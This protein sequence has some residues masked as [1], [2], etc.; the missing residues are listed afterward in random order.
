MAY[1]VRFLSS[2][3]VT[4]AAVALV[5]PARAHTVGDWEVNSGARSCTM[6]STFEDNVSIGLISPRNGA[7]SFVAGGE[8]L[9]AF[10]HP[11]Q[12]VSLDLK[13]TGKVPHDE[14][15][16]DRAAVSAASDG[17]PMVVA[18]WGATYAQ[19][20]ADTVTASSAVTVSVGGK[21]LGTYDLSGSPAAYRRLSRCGGELAA[22]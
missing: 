22:K 14:W 16:A 12:N 19:E 10:V 5:A 17:G 4:A 7:L 20:L 2:M 15:S 21:T 11:G 3:A 18:D 9:A 8:G 6:L 1:P 13:F